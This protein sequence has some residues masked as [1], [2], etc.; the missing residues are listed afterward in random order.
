[1]LRG[2][3]L[4][5]C[6]WFV[7]ANQ[8]CFHPLPPKCLSVADADLS[9]KSRKAFVRYRRAFKRLFV[10]KE[11]IDPSSWPF[12]D[13][14]PALPERIGCLDR[15]IALP[16]SEITISSVY[17]DPHHVYKVFQGY[18]TGIDIPAPVGTPVLAPADGEVSAVKD[19]NV[20]D[21]WYVKLNLGDGWGVRFV[22]L[23][24]IAVN[25]GD[26][27]RAGDVVGWSGGEPDDYGS[28]EYTT[29]PHLHF[30]VF[31]QGAFTDPRPHFCA[32]PLRTP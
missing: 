14:A 27:V 32:A 23:S 11:D 10:K 22:H 9:L 29:G 3:L 5:A 16:A 15:P 4:C 12:D 30:D 20:E 7:A 26:P 6:A 19:Q 28:G 18:H 13:H 31:Y 25:V 21:A 24:R 17:R 2:L 1:M 8:G